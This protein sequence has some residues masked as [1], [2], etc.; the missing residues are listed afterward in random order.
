MRYIIGDTETTGLGP[1]RKAVDVALM[2]VEEDLGCFGSVEAMLN[3]ERLID[4][5]ASEIHGIYDADVADKLTIEQWVQQELHGGLEGDIMLIGYR[6]AFDRPMLGCIGNIVD[7]FDLLPLVQQFFPDLPNHKLQ[8][9]REHLGLPGGTAHRAMGDV[10]T[11]YELLRVLI[12]KTGRTL[13]QH[14]STKFRVVHR[15]P[16]GAH[17]GKLLADVPASYR[18]WMLDKCEDLDPHLRQS[19]ELI[20]KTDL[21]P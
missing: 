2:E 5:S 19:L 7:I 17:A 10:I 11:T 18:R 16:W 13:E 1:L 12:P 14:C 20:R 15:Q 3:P 9:I 21:L 4:A 8:T 6:I